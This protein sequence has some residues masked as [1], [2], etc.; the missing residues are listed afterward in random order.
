MEKVEHEKAICKES[1]DHTQGKVVILEL[2]LD[3]MTTNLLDQVVISKKNK[4]GLKV[5]KIH[6]A[7]TSSLSV[8]PQEQYLIPN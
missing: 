7:T 4:N 1:L 2:F 5:D 6:N 8:Y 3:N